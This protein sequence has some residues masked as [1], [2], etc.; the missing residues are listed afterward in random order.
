MTVTDSSAARPYH[1]HNISAPAF[2]T[3]DFASRDT[4]FAELRAEPGL[5]WHPP[6]ESPFPHEEKGYWAVTK[7]ADLRHISMHSELFVSSKGISIDP[8]PA[9]IQRTT[10]FFLTMDPP[11]HT[12]YRR[13]ISSAFTP[14]QVRRIQEQIQSNAAEIVDDLLAKLLTGQEVDFVADCAAKLPMRTISDMI[15]IDPDDR[16]RIA[17]AAESLSGGTDDEYST[18]EDRAMHMMAQFGVLTEAG[19]EL[20][21]RRRET[22]CE[23]LM[24]NIVNA[25]VDGHGLSDTEIG[26]F[27]VLLSVAGNDTTKQATSHT[28]KALIEHPEQRAWLLEDFDAR[29]D[30]AID[31]FVRWATPVMSFARHA[32]ADT[33]VGG[34]TVRAGDKLALFYC[35][36]NRDESVF[37]DPDQFDLTRSPN[38]HLGFGAGTH[39][40]LGSQLAR[41][42]LRRLFHELLTRLPEVSLGEPEY[43]HSM[44]I[45]GIKRMPLALGA[46]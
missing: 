46:R 33:E 36:A 22:P 28:F 34:T 16:E 31:E 14:R 24:T 7:H 27:L 4:V 23:D 20:A 42:E 35:S 32:V 37:A 3:G 13:L 6:M 29:I 21:R 39:F 1:A 40:C 17:H 43:L 9:E 10:T 12:R 25:E 11:E 45:H 18:L 26:A 15:G 30:T 8:L 44:F 41:M 38:P 19:V 5:S 2:W